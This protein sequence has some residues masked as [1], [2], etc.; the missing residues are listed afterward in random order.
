MKPRVVVTRLLSLSYC[1][2]SN[3]ELYR[4]P[5]IDW[6]ASYKVQSIV[7]TALLPRG[8]VPAIRNVGA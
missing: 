6:F 1:K 2:N 8:A 5:F 4:S 7:G 3:N